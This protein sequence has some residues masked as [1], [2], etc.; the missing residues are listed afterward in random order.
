MSQLNDWMIEPSIESIDGVSDLAGRPAHLH[1][2]LHS[3]HSLLSSRLASLPAISLLGGDR[4]LGATYWSLTLPAALSESRRVVSAA[5]FRALD[6][7]LASSS[8]GPRARERDGEPHGACRGVSTALRCWATR[9]FR[10]P[11]LTLSRPPRKSRPRWRARPTSRICLEETIACCWALARDSL[12]R[13]VCLFKIYL[14][15][16]ERQRG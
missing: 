4:C 7:G 8:R 3:L 11:T 15:M 14:L 16:A 9:T 12:L 13:V 1:D 5:A 2:S 10:T 6:P